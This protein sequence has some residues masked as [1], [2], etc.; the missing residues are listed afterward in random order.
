LAAV[1]LAAAVLAAGSLV[2]LVGA[3]LL[4]GREV[5]PLWLLLLG[6]VGL[7]IG[8]VL[9][10]QLTAMGMPAPLRLLLLALLVFLGVPGAS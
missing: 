6:V 1:V 5:S 2:G 4:A 7:V 3:F 8:L 10:K 9:Q